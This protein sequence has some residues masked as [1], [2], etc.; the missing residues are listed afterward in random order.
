MCKI[1]QK[2]IEWD[3]MHNELFMEEAKVDEEKS[4]ISNSI[5]AEEEETE[6]D[7]PMNFGDCE[8]ILA[9]GEEKAD[10]DLNLAQRL[11]KKLTNM[12][13]IRKGLS[14]RTAATYTT[15]HARTKWRASPCNRRWCGRLDENI[16][17]TWSR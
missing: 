17:L 14:R 5:H 9:F 8:F 11:A 15:R 6:I 10:R 1:V 16:W 13:R 3:E 7:P 2:S 4:D 12:I